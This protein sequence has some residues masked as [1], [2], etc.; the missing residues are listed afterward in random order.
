VRV[1]AHAPT[2]VLADELTGNLDADNGNRVVERLR[3]LHQH[4]GSTMLMVTH[5][6]G[7]TSQADR[8]L[9]LEVGQLREL[10]P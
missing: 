10:V 1:L 8:I 6:L 4:V 5:S 2:L 3:Q 9:R 7:I